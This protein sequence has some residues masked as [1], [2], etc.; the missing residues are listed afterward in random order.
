[1]PEARRGPLP[2][3][4]RLRYRC[5]PMF[6]CAFAFPHPWMATLG[7]ELF[8]MHSHGWQRHAPSGGEAG[9][10]GVGAPTGPRATRSALYPSSLILY[11]LEGERL[12]EAFQP[13]STDL[14][15][16]EARPAPNGVTVYSRAASGGRKS[17]TSRSLVTGQG[18]RRRGARDGIAAGGVG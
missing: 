17:R 2:L 11:P 12:R 8:Q 3:A 4:F 15:R 7:M 9:L 10:L 18:P 14:E 5:A 13:A 6:C 1:V 16:G